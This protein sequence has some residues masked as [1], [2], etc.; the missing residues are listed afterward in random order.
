MGKTKSSK[1]SLKGP[2]TKDE[3]K[4]WRTLLQTKRSEITQDISDLIK[5]AMDAEDGHVAPTHQADRGSGVDFQE[6][7]L[8]MVG[9]EEQ[10]LWQID[11]AIRKIDNGTPL[12]FGLC[13]YTQQP[14]PRTRL[15]LLPWTPLS[16]DGANAME[17]QNLTIYDM[18]L[19]D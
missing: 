13:E 2:F 9:N 12:P 7:S 10:I 6:F 19:D 8:D 11:R 1:A 18:V 16:I 14:I 3:L 15:R 4:K 17:E 5:D